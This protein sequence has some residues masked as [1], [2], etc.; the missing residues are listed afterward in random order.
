MRQEL[1]AN[2]VHMN[3]SRRIFLLSAPLLLTGAT[4]AVSQEAPVGQPGGNV[5]LQIDGDISVQNDQD[6]LSLDQT[7]LDALPQVEFATSTIWTQEIDIFSGP[8]LHSLIDFAGSGTGDVIAS[9]LNDYSITIPRSFIEKTAPIVASRINGRTFSIREKG[10]LWIIFPYDKSEHYRS[11]LIYA[12]S[13]W[14]LRRLTVD[15]I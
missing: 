9:A 1:K 15:R 3:V 2:G 12:L 14:Q 5:L 10:P 13:V 6:Q 11:E 8:T 7:M 4:V